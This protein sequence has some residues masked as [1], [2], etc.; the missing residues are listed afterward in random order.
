MLNKKRYWKKYVLKYI[1]L[2]FLIKERLFNCLTKRMY[3]KKT[4]DNKR[5]PNKKGQKKITSK[6][7]PEDITEECVIVETY[8][9]KTVDSDTGEKQTNVELW[10]NNGKGIGNNLCLLSFIVFGV[11]RTSLHPC[12]DQLLCESSWSTSW[13][14]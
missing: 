3:N 14:T 2:R 9:P 6:S 4:V 7:C 8:N 1:F 5:G 13:F 12:K 11:E 10:S